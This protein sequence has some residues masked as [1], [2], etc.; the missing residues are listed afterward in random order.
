M[1]R[2]E[3]GKS[4]TRPPIFTSIVGPLARRIRGMG[5]AMLSPD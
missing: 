1:R 4:L 5:K 2:P 3:L